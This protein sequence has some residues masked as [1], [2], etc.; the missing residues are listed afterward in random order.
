VPALQPSLQLDAPAAE[1]V[2]SVHAL[3]AVEPSSSW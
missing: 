3:H 2:P 1:V